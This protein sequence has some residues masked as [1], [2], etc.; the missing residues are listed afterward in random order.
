LHSTS[1]NHRRHAFTVL[2]IFVVLGIVA[3]FLALLVPFFLRMR[4]SGKAGECVR[5]MQ[6][7]GKAIQD[8]AKD[9]DDQLPGPLSRGQHPVAS[10]GQPPRD[11]QLLKYIGR[12]LDQPSN[13]P[14]GGGN[15]STIF[16]FPAWER[17][18][19]RAMDAPVFIVNTETALPFEQSVWGGDGKPPIKMSELPKWQRKI[20]GKLETIPLSKIWA[21]TEAD[22][23]ICKILGVTEPWIEG[24]PAKPLHYN[25][26]N[27]LYFDWHVDTL[28][29]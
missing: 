18:S 6:L 5:N 12:Y 23:E 14:E 28:A 21:L 4:Q 22:R 9:H 29:L 8:Y 2:E 10:A 24:L 7:I 16:T 11:G 26:R 1:P 27:A 3:C 15:A 13:A 25:H 19:E 17:Y 20:T